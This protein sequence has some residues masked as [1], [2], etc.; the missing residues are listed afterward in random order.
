M[1]DK[2]Q[3]EVGGF[4]LTYSLRISIVPLGKEGLAVGE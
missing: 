4:I 1:L 2:K 3:L